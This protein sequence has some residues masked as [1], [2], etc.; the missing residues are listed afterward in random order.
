MSPVVPSAVQR[1][2]DRIVP[3]E[4]FP[5]K[6]AFCVVAGALGIIVTIGKRGTMEIDGVKK[7]FIDTGAPFAEVHLVQAD[8][9][10][11]NYGHFKRAPED[12]G[13]NAEGEPPRGPIGSVQERGGEIFNVPFDAIER[14]PWSIVGPVVDQRNGDE[15]K[16]D[17]L[18]ASRAGYLLSDEEQAQLPALLEAETT[19]KEQQQFLAA[20]PEAAA[21]EE[22]IERDRVTFIQQQATKRAELAARLLAARSAGPAPMAR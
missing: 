12:F 14:A 4:R 7:D 5:R 13:L 15:P 10:H 9:Q 22:E 1:V 18:W 8:E 6:G 16:P 11:P 17:L 3:A 19:A 20:Q 2:G 21:L